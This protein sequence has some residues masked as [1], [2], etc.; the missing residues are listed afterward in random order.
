MLIHF[1]E[2]ALLEE[3]I[4]EEYDILANNN[5]QEALEQLEY[6]QLHSSFK[7][8]KL[9]LIQKFVDNQEFNLKN[10]INE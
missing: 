10:H 8:I 9:S 6:L 2:I 5:I 1:N 4:P 3:N 7:D